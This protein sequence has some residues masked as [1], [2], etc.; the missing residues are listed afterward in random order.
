MTWATHRK[1][2]YTLCV[3]IVVGGI[4]FV[5]IRNAITVA[6]TCFD[7]K[8]N[9]TEKGVDCGGACMRYCPNELKDPKVRWVRTFPVTNKL[10]HAIAYIEHS[11]VGAAAREVHYTFRVYDAK[12]TLIT[13]RAGTTFIGPMGTS[14]VVETLLPMGNSTPVLTRF[15]ITEPIVWEKV[16]KDLSS[17]VI[18]T[19]KSFIEPLDGTTRLSATLENKSRFGFTNMEA[20][21]ILYDEQGNAITTSKSLVPSLPALESK[22]VYFTWPF[23]VSKQVSRIE[24][25]SR[26]NPFTAESL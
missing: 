22:T 16:S 23:P 1:L 7:A 24:V 15:T 20:I 9:G 21:A 17:V 26:F 12:N 13:E 8:K 6:P 19:D 4:A 11:N 14:A 18:K 10:V 5:A 3:M 2:M 25:I